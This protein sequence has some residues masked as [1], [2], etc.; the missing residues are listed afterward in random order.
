[1]MLNSQTTFLSNSARDTATAIPSLSEV[2]WVMNG[3]AGL[4]TSPDTMQST[5]GSLEEPNLSYSPA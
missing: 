4:E 5:R 1:M 2:S 3:L